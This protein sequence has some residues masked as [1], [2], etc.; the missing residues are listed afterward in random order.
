MGVFL[1]TL[2]DK[3]S[4]SLKSFDVL[5]KFPEGC[6][7]FEE[8]LDVCKKHEGKPFVMVVDKSSKEGF[9]SVERFY[10]FGTVAVKDDGYFGLKCFT[11]RMISTY[12]PFF[13]HEIH[14]IDIGIDDSLPYE[15]KIAS[16]SFDI[17]FFETML[18]E[19]FCPYYPIVLKN[20]EHDLYMMTLLGY[21][22]LLTEPMKQYPFLLLNK[23]M[24][25][26]VSFLE[27][28][29]KESKNKDKEKKDKKVPV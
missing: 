15:C 21:V 28:K 6:N 12:I 10:F 20:R 14:A 3:R 19:H 16:M 8:F 24:N 7:S 11:P 17:E 4:E 5:P 9:A 26:I 13:F 27:R 2:F 29:D 18:V 23:E 25:T 1:S 22:H